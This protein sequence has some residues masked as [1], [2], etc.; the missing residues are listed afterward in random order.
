MSSD[1]NHVERDSTFRFPSFLVRAASLQHNWHNV[2]LLLLPKDRVG[3]AALVFIARG[4]LAM[5]LN[6]IHAAFK[7]HFGHVM[8]SHG[9]NVRLN[10][11]LTHCY[12][13]N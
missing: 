10:A 8:L 1:R 5:R 3:A 6:A 12:S 2:Y 7:P 13:N 4:R 9:A 11:A